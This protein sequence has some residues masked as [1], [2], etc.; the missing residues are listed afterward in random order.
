MPRTNGCPRASSIQNHNNKLVRL[1]PC[2]FGYIDRS[3]PTLEGEGVRNVTNVPFP[4]TGHFIVTLFGGDTPPL[5]CPSLTGRP[6]GGCLTDGCLPFCRTFTAA[7]AKRVVFPL[8]AVLSLKVLCRHVIHVP[9]KLPIALADL[10]P[11]C[12]SSTLVP[13]ISLSN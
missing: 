6:L 4:D 13:G 10:E 7:F 8:S 12:R 5:R 3:E 9:C 1:Q 2:T 11:R